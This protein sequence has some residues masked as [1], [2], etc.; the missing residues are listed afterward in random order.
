MRIFTKKS[1]EFKNVAAGEKVRTRPLEF[2]DVPDW[3]REDPVFAW[4]VKDGD[5]TIAETA[6]DEA[7]IEK[8]ADEPE[9]A[10]DEARG[11]KTSRAAK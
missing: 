5:I 10:Q 4:G 1:F 6:Q 2:A 11:K 7:A 3:A 8:A 9:T